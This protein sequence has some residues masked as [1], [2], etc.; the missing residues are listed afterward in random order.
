MNRKFFSSPYLIYVGE[1]YFCLCNKVFLNGFA[2]QRGAETSLVTESG[3]GPIVISNNELQNSRLS[4][5]KTGITFFKIFAKFSGFE[6]TS[7]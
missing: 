3:K 5:S 7:T 4:D 6:I 2:S 1:Q